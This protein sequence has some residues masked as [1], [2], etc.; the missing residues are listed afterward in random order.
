MVTPV[1]R[2]AWNAQMF[3]NRALE[4]L[5]GQSSFLGTCNRAYNDQRASYNRGDSIEIKGI[6]D[7][8]V[9][10]ESA[11]DFD[12]LDPPSISL[13]LTDYRHVSFDIGD[14]D[15][16]YGPDVFDMHVGPATLKLASGF[17]SLYLIRAY[18]Q[19]GQHHIP[20]TVAVGDIT[21]AQK[22]LDDSNVPT[23]DEA[24]MFFLTSTALNKAFLDLSAFTQWQGSGE[25]GASDQASGQLSRRYGFNFLKT[26][27]VP[28]YSAPGSALSTTTLAVVGA[29]AKEATT[30]NLDAGSVTGAMNPGTV[31]TIAGDTTKYSVTNTVTAS[32]NAL[33]GVEISP[34]LRV[35]AADNAVVTVVAQSNFNAKPQSLAYH[36]NAFAFAA[37]PLPRT[38]K[39]FA[40]ADVGVAVDPVSGLSVRVA[41][42]WDFKTGK[43]MC[44]VDML[45]GFKVI[46]P[47]MAV[48]VMA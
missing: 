5:L 3:A 31:F 18:Q 13:K 4:Y 32:G 12:G 43:N 19:I 16:A 39:H 22:I 45:S 2:G 30:I 21:A 48:R 9:R 26:S 11:M 47:E 25:R 41:R 17:T 46:Q 44:R 1:I 6:Q 42:G 20:G 34:P 23:D 8:T 37:A 40:S 29:T 33:A 35:A 38:S 27:L 15:S 24:N 36:R 7:L 14:I 28:T 10:D